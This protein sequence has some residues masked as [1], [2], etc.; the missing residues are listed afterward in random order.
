[1]SGYLAPKFARLIIRRL[2]VE[3]QR[4]WSRKEKLLNPRSAPEP[5][6]C[7]LN[8]A[9]ARFADPAR[10]REVMADV[11]AALQ[12]CRMQSAESE[13]TSVI[14]PF[15]RQ[16]PIMELLLQDPLTAHSFKK[17]RG[18]PGDAE[19]LDLVYLERGR[20]KNSC[21][22]TTELGRQ[23]FDYTSNVAACK[24]VRARKN[25]LG[26]EIVG[27]CSRFER[28]RILSVA[29]GHLRELAFVD[30][31]TNRQF[32][33]LVA[34]DQDPISVQYV[35]Q[36]WSHLHVRP[37][38]GHIKDLAKNGIGKFHLVYAAGLYD[39]LP[40]SSACKLTE[41]L[42]SCLDLGGTL[43]LANFLQNIWESGY[44]EA[45]MDWWLVQRTPSEIEA[46]ASAIPKTS[47]VKCDCWT[48]AYDRIGY[49]RLTK[50]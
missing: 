42:F 38:S 14:V 39:Y 40:T 27:V 7:V 20:V 23:I 43:L 36:T 48:G 34:F 30:G 4:R 1:M 35:H 49:L 28:P 29:C 33:E 21:G 2:P 15:V 22:A 41:L 11:E 45:V 19:L 17:P 18:Y 6:C 46:F 47:I 5:L 8:D 32:A 3:F 9:V 12:R 44:M 24:A 16:H 25:H 10:S 37:V 31:R 26:N 50:T 13:W